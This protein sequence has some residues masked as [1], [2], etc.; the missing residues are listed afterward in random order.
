LKTFKNI[1]N[2]YD[3]LYAPAFDADPKVN[4]LITYVSCQFVEFTQFIK[5]F[6]TFPAVPGVG[7]VDT[8]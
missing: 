4:P 2:P 6:G 7:I 8:L 3:A 1:K 5:I